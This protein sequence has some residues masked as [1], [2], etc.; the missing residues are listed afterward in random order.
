MSIGFGYA[1]ATKNTA[2]ANN[3]ISCLRFM[4]IFIAQQHPH[5]GRKR[6]YAFASDRADARAYE[7]VGFHA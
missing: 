2:A 7:I 1:A 3:G 6:R 5:G 4:P